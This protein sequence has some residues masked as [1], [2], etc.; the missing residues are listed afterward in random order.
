MPGLPADEAAYAP[1]ARHFSEQVG[2]RGAHVPGIHRFISWISL[3]LVLSAIASPAQSLRRLETDFERDINR[4]RWF[5]GVTVQQTVSNRVL[6]ISNRFSSD[7]F[8]LFNDLL[9]FR[10][11]NI[12]N[13]A[14]SPTSGKRTSLAFRGNLAAFSQS[15]VLSQQ[16]YGTLAFSVRDLVDIE[17]GIG[18]ALDQRPGA[19]T[20]SGKAPLRRDIG[21]AIATLIALRP[22]DAGGYTLQMDATGNLQ[23]ITPRR[24]RQLRMNGRAERLFDTTR[25]ASTVFYSNV[26]RDAY[27][28]V[29]F[30]NR[31]AAITPLSETIEAT[32]SDTLNIGLELDAPIAPWLQLSN[33]IDFTSNNRRIRT[34]RTPE[35]S[36]F[37]DTDFN[38]RRIDVSIGLDVNTRRWV[39]RLS[40]EGT[41]EVE[42]RQLTNRED[43][44][45][46]QATQKADL[47]EQADYDRSIIGV[48][49]QNR[50][51]L[52]RNLVMQLE[53]SANILRHDTPE[54]NQDD[55]D[56]SF[57]SAEVQLEYKMSRF[58]TLQVDVFGTYYHTVYLKA[59]RSAENNVQRS[60]RFRPA[61]EWT[62]TERTY[63]RVR[64]GVR[65]TYTVDDFVLEGRR[66]TDQSARELQYDGEFRQDLGNDFVLSATGGLSDLRL[67]RFLSDSFAE[68]PF[69]T[70]QTYNGWVRLQSGKTIRTEIGMRVFVRTDFERATSVQYRR[71]D[72]AGA[73]VFDASGNVVRST[74]TRPG[75]RWIEQ[76]GPTIAISWIMSKGSQFRVNG[77]LNIQRIRQRLYGDLPEGLSEHIRAEARRG[78]TRTIPNLSVSVLWNL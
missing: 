39:S 55:R 71:I 10:D 32:T 56:E 35:E 9:S 20:T 62:P 61:I 38:R 73:L 54:S 18:I 49:F 77:W 44:P 41:T 78:T 1:F 52:S 48:R 66:P 43:V 23:L 45:A 17:P 70:L 46:I 72:E 37:F 67:G 57:L 60:L 36:L 26:R 50:G 58:V 63:L 74:I 47:L 11:E 33:R 28:S 59:R 65:A 75:R 4:Y 27:Q 6:Q 64:S 31:D 19:S 42:T 12:L 53:T 21:P 22:T 40:L 16:A 2:K 25:F 51:F 13:W 8:I 7:A 15:R 14:L 29:S 30:L 5:S 68:I 34:L 24:G 76:I 3:L 69:D